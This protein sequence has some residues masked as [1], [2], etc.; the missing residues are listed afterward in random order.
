MQCLT[1]KQRFRSKCS[2]TKSTELAL[3]FRKNE[4]FSVKFTER[5]LSVPETREY[6]AHDSHN[7]NTKY[8][9]FGD[10]NN[11]GEKCLFLSKNLEGPGSTQ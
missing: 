9:F 6:S 8:F 2:V 5:T 4:G 3:N 7:R 11:S 10:D 1:K